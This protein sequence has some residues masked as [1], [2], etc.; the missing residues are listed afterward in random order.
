MSRSKRCAAPDLRDLLRIALERRSRA[1]GRHEECI[2]VAQRKGL[3][4]LRGA[5]IH[6][7]RPRV[8]VGLG[9]GAHPLE[10]EEPPM[11]IEIAAFRPGS[12]DDIE[13]FLGEIV[14]GVVLA[15]RHPEHLELALV[16]SDYEIDTEASFADVVGGYEFLGR[17]QRVK[18]RR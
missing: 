15:L 5:G 18:E 11:E 8:A 10:V 1:R 12:L 7:D 9:V 6:D 14:A 2:A 3:S 16:P 4:D 17:D 13:P